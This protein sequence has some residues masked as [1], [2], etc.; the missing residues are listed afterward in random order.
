MQQMTS[1][2]ELAVAVGR[3]E[4]KQDSLKEQFGNHSA[5][6][7]GFQ[8]SLQDAVS[9]QSSTLARHETRLDGHDVELQTI[10]GDLK[11]Q[12]T[13]NTVIIGLILT[14]VNLVFGILSKLQ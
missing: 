1:D 9:A 2:S 13:K 10:R 7:T 12:F 8:T 14:G 4:A 5:N 6:S 11:G 3:I